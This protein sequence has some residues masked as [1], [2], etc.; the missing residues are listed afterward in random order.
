MGKGPE[1]ASKMRGSRTTASKRVEIS[2]I[3]P[4]G[5]ANNYMCWEEDPR[6]KKCSLINTLIVAL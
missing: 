4:Q 3:Q 1:A 2:E 6:Q 5:N